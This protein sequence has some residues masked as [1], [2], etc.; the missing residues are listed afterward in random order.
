MADRD[1]S[2][3]ARLYY[4]HGLT[5]GE[6]AT[7]M[8]L[9]RVKVTRMLAEA[10]RTGIVEI[11]IHG[12]SHAFVEL[13]SQLIRKFGLIN[14][15]VVPSTQDVDRQFELL[16]IGGAHALEELVA[17][18]STVAVGLSRAVSSIPRALGSARQVDATFVPIVGSRAG[19]D[20]INAHE[21]CE[22]LARTFGGR[23][24]HL[25]APVMTR[26]ADLAAVLRKEPNIKHALELA[27]KA[28]LF[29][30]GIGGSSQETYLVKHGDITPTEFSELVAS[31]AVGDLSGR[32][33]DGEGRPVPSALN[34][35]VIALN[36]EQ[37][38]VIPT[39]VGVVGGAGKRKAA[40]GA[41]VAGI[42]NVV[43][44]DV[45]TAVWLVAQH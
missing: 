6:I 44:T 24:H 12:D 43:V 22:A 37:L 10:R 25:P 15:W 19:V 20:G 28:E 42:V 38:S 35:R 2:R 41:I 32:F 8:G 45:D 18:G 14:A 5:Q 36:L 27:E 30:A 4:E 40:R 7:V 29:V 11:R 21:T 16:G 17:P 33:F 23:A 39:R 31:G 3:V 13:E 34:D 26:S 1:L 9:S